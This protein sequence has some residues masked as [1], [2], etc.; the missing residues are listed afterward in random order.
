MRHFYKLIEK[1]KVVWPMIIVCN[2]SRDVI[3]YNISRFRVGHNSQ[4]LA[5]IWK[6]DHQAVVAIVVPCFPEI[7]ILAFACHNNT[8]SKTGILLSR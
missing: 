3:Y 7:E 8:Q 2:D 1:R 4:P 6:H 5:A